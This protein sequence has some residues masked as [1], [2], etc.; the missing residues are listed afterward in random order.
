MRLRQ[1]SE[2]GVTKERTQTSKPKKLVIQPD[3]H[4]NKKAKHWYTPKTVGPEAKCYRWGT[5]KPMSGDGYDE[6]IMTVGS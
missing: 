3:E 6:H 5:G 4:Q 2:G 1:L